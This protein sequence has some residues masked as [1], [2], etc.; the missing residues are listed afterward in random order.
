ML[1]VSRSTSVKIGLAPQYNTAFAVAAN[2]KVSVENIAGSIVIQGWDKNEVQLTGELGDSVKELKTNASQSA[3]QITVINHKRQR[4]DNTK[5]RLRIPQTAIIDASAVSA[6]IDI[7][8]L[9]SEKLSA[10]S[11]SGEL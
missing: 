1:K 9:H 2:V 6:D 5:L 11:V 8:D 4:V 3:V 10:A 7:S